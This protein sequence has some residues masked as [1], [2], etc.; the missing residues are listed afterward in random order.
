MET[1]RNAYL[2]QHLYASVKESTTPAGKKRK[3]VAHVVFM[4]DLP[5]TDDV[6]VKNVI[7]LTEKQVNYLATT[8]RLPVGNLSQTINLLGSSIGNSR[9]YAV[10]S[11]EFHKKG[12]KYVDSDGVE[13]LY[14]KDWYNNRIDS[15][16]LPESLTKIVDEK[17]ASIMIGNWES[18]MTIDPSGVPE[19]TL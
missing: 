12:D 2:I 4:N 19:G 5:N 3:T 6:K 16:K 7:S 11:S 1:V 10:V 13:K 15:L 14:E 17:L 9:S 18:V 8:Q